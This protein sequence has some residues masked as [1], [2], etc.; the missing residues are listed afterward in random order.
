MR[1]LQVGRGWWALRRERFLGLCFV[2]AFAMVA[3]VP[4]SASAVS[5]YGAAAWGN[6]LGNGT[7]EYFASDVA[8]AVSGLSGVTAVSGGARHSLALLS[9]GTVMAW[10]NNNHGQLVTAASPPARC[11][12]RCAG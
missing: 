6:D 7:E 5:P 9:N 3:M 4:T 10:N 2:A 12:W 8:V 1:V 11:R